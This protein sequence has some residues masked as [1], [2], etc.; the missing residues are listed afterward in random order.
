MLWNMPSVIPESRSAMKP[1]V[2]TLCPMPHATKLTLHCR[3]CSS[4]MDESAAFAF[5]GAFACEKCVRDHYRKRPLAE[6][7]RELQDRRREAIRMMP[8]YRKTLEKLAAKKTT[9]EKKTALIVAE[10][11]NLALICIE[12]GTEIHVSTAF[13]YGGGVAC[14]KCV[15]DYYRDR[16]TELEYELQLRR[17]NAITWVKLNRK[18]LEK[19]AAKRTV[20]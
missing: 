7:A 3:E 19:Q 18:T 5:R 8:E 16:P 4:E 17:R 2:S 13:E 20:Q 12:C 11:Q 1:S 10:L 9:S 14:E 15:R 6:I